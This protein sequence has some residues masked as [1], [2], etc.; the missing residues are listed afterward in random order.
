MR[1]PLAAQY[2]GK[3]IGLASVIFVAIASV[4]FALASHAGLMGFPLMGI[5][6]V[7]FF[8]YGLVTVE[9]VAWN[10]VDEPVLSVEML[11]PLSQSKSMVLLFVTGIFFAIFYA[12][13]YWLGNFAG[14]IVGLAAVGLL[15]AVI[16]VQTAKDTA[17]A[18]L[19][20]VDWYH[21]IR[22]LKSDY[23]LV[24]GCI[25]IYWVLAF[26]LE[27][28]PL[29]EA[30]PLFARVA[31]LM[32]GWLAVCALL[33]GAI[34]ERRISDPD[35]SPVERYEA[36]TPPEEVARQREGK[37]DSIYGEW[38]SGAEKNAWQT[39]MR[40]AEE[41][42]DAVEELRWMLARISTWPEKRLGNRVAQEL[43]PRLLSI[44]RFSEAITVTRQRLAADPEYRPVTSMETLRMVRVAR[45]GGDRPTARALLGDFR[46][47]FPNDPLQRA[48]D[49]LVEQLKR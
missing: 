4:A 31:M 37:I 15:P 9:H 7:W 14:S 32:F 1:L 29:R 10:Q 16:A 42:G 2:L 12:A 47:I 8:K 38:R 40:T 28:T 46:R 20:P 17:L 11:H 30:V 25:L 34:R 13:R 26:I 49:D 27:V 41:S 36:A 3:A 45:D 19:N 22:W 6:S 5:M 18:A 24:L 23:L 44:S 33:G 35:D 48:A 43:V 39:L 21:A